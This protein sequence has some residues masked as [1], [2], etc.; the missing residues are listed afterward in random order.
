MTN[1]KRL[2]MITWGCQMNVY[3]SGRMAD[4]L[5]PLGYGPAERPDD[6]DMIILNTCHIRDKA[7][8]KVFPELGRLRL[9]LGQTRRLASVG[10]PL[11][12][13]IDKP[14]LDVV[15]REGVLEGGELALEAAEVGLAGARGG[16][17]GGGADAGKALVGRVEGGEGAD[18]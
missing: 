12:Q 2:H 8:E 14:I 11:G 9:K 16:V 18:R 7:A 1:T 10:A 4:V 17:L 3:D 6:A 15:Q 13:T 5:S